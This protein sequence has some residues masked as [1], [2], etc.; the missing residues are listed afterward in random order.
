MAGRIPQT[1]IDDLLQRIDIVDV[2]DARVPLHKAGKDHQA[3]CPFHNEKTA[4]FTVSQAKQFYHCF[5][6][7]ASGTAIGFLMEYAHM[8]FP[9]A[10]ENLAAQVGLEIPSSNEREAPEQKQRRQSLLDTI[11]SA[12]AYYKQMLRKHEGTSRA[13]SYLKNRGVSGEVAASFGLG[14]AP[15]G[16]SNLMDAL[17]KTDDT[18]GT[19][20][21]LLA[22]G[23]LVKNE[24]GRTYDRFRD[25]IMFPIQDYRGRVVAFGGR[26]LGDGEP[27]YMN[28]PE[29]PLFH[30]GSELY[31][32]F[33]ARGAIREAQKS[34]V[35]EGYMDVVA[36][37]Q[38]GINYATATLGT[39]TTSMH[40]QRLFK[41]TPEIVFSFDGDRAGRAAAWRALE[42]TLPEMQDG[43]QV[44]FLFL[45]DGEDP[46][47]MVRSDGRE[48]FEQRVSKSQSIADYLIEQLTKELDLERLDGRARLAERARP[49]LQ[50]IPD[51][52]FKQLLVEEF[53]RQCH[54]QPERLLLSKQTPQSSPAN[55]ALSERQPPTQNRKIH[56]ALELLLQ[57]PTLALLE[58]DITPLANS[59]LRGFD[60]LV[61]LQNV[62]ISQPELSLAMVLERFRE[63]KYH[64][65]LE[66]LAI[67][68]HEEPID[69]DAAK[70]GYKAALHALLR[71]AAEV[72]SSLIAE[73]GFSSQN[74][75]DMSEEE[76]QRYNELI[77][78]Q[79]ADKIK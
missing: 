51:G 19:G 48:A 12:D 8:E 27:K 16:W 47:S 53:A 9:E 60:L 13:V 64:P 52:V 6:C 17:V 37:A 79:N 75:N 49:H 20:K 57:H 25:R 42:N 74:F 71:Q 72:E 30:K 58:I 73:K 67:Q 78:K 26:V 40:L 34:L 35:V 63:H 69:F 32:L 24:S 77:R 65:A 55:T 28:S 14:F 56:N 3:R 4:S 45:P 54:T 7:G 43:R 15:Q 2:I 70:S 68:D 61:E 59:G 46:D 10:V 18:D 50:K 31:G 44:S 23:L 39:A 38:H 1:F 41:V 29:H 5:G 62:F 21:R 66:K 22:A 76:K 11:A 36:L 33:R